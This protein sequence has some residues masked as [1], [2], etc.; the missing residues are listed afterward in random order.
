MFAL[1][2]FCTAD[3]SVDKLISVDLTCGNVSGCRCLKLQRRCQGSSVRL[4]VEWCVEWCLGHSWWFLRVNNA[5]APC[6]FERFETNVEQVPNKCP[7]WWESQ[8]WIL[9]SLAPG[10][11][12]WT[13]GRHQLCWRTTGACSCYPIMMRSCVCVFYNDSVNDDDDIW[14]SDN[15]CLVFTIYYL[16]MFVTRG[17]W[18]APTLGS[19]SGI[20][21]ILRFFRWIK[22]VAIG[23]GVTT[24]NTTS[25]DI[26]NISL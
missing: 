14:L 7:I 19:P 21:S 1:R 17:R 4:P 18:S 24:Y 13:S 16:S 3:A 10:S 20:C 25:I 22:A 23:D 12:R 9:L 5:Q 26:Y 6:Q 8:W 2:Y 11:L 15:V